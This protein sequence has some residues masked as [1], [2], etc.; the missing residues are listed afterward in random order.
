[1]ASKNTILGFGKT[2]RASDS[3]VYVS[4]S[5]RDWRRQTLDCGVAGYQVG[6][7]RPTP[8]NKCIEIWSDRENF[9][10]LERSWY[11]GRGGGE[12]ARVERRKGGDSG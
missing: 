9:L 12:A 8:Y 3:V 4:Q 11:R 2:P 10:V 1:M 5:G 7:K 6:I